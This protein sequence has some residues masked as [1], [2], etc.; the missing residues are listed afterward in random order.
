MSHLLIKARCVLLS[1]LKN[2]QAAVLINC[3]IF[4]HVPAHLTSQEAV[5]PGGVTA[6]QVTI[7][8]LSRTV[9]INTCG[10][11]KASLTSCG[12]IG[13][14]KYIF[15]SFK[16][17]HTWC[18]R[19]VNVKTKVK[20]VYD[21]PINRLIYCKIRLKLLNRDKHLWYTKAVKYQFFPIS[22]IE[23]N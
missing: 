6:V 2:K 14:V 15:K 20:Q 1:S 17:Y 22:K 10:N 21:K 16:D 9:G 12:R 18:S 5:V 7:M 8:L 4:C 13:Q 23:T 11:S 19:W 3:V